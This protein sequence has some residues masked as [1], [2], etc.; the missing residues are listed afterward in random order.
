MGFARNLARQR[1]KQTG[2]VSL[3]KAADLLGKLQGMSE[4]AE[5]LKPI[6]EDLK[7]ARLALAMVIQDQGEADRRHERFRQALLAAL[8]EHDG[9]DHI[10]KVIENYEQQLD[11]QAEEEPCPP[12]PD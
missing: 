6:G 2:N 4:L 11:R 3:E 5:V 7:E 9:F 12:P 8:R 1:K 10:E